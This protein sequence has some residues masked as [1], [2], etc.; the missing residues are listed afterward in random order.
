[1][2][3]ILATLTT[4][5]QVTIPKKVR[6]RLRLSPHDIIAF[7]LEDDGTVR[8][9]AP[10]YPSVAALRGAA[11]TLTR[12]LTWQQMREISRDDHLAAGREHD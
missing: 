12:R 10:R 6:E 7:V 8:L 3:E 2:D 11:G 9:Q 4:K 1:M 5:G